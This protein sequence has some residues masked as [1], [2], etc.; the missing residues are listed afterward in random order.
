MNRSFAIVSGKG[1]VGKTTAALNLAVSAVQV[2]TSAVVVDAALHAPNVGVHLGS[3]R[4][5]A[6]LHDL[7]AGKK[8]PHEA[9]YL[10]PSGMRVLPA[11]LAVDHDAPVS[12]ENLSSIVESLR[13][14][15][16]LVIVDASPGLGPDVSHALL[17]AGNALLMTTPD[18]P[19]VSGALRVKTLCDHLGVPIAGVLLNRV[20]FDD[21]ELSK[22]NVAS[23]LDLPVIAMIPDDDAVRRSHRLRHPVTHTHPMSPAALA[24]K[25]A[26]ADIIRS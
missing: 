8:Q 2:G 26:A 15:S 20:R 24:F 4:L 21:V 18:L 11:G 19:A 13:E 12:L 6:T 10:H 7:L 22:E 17:A 16:E 1:G 25:S 5:G 14:R 23:L 3:P 9:I